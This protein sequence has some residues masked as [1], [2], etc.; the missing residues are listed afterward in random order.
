MNV[1]TDIVLPGA[2]AFIMFSMGLSLRIADFKR[3]L[4]QPKA[5]IVGLTAQ[6]VFL[7]LVAFAL[8]L[9]WRAVFGLNPSLAVGFV[10]IAACPGGVTSNLMTHMARG[11]TA[12]SISLTAVSSVLS[13]ITIPLIVNAAT[14]L[15]L[16]AEAPPLP[17]LGTVAGVFAI[18]T[19][20]VVLGMLVRGLASH[21]AVRIEPV[22][23]R[24]AIG[25]FVV[26]VLAAVAL[27]WRLLAENFLDVVPLVLLLNLSTM[28]IGWSAAR[29]ARLTRERTIAITLEAGLQ[30]G[31]LA[32]LIAATFLADE[33]M[34]V[35]GAIYSILM[36]FTAGL[37]VAR[38]VRRSA[39]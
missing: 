14:A 34:V 15:F 6:M 17:I 24:A 26:I 8:V 1:V 2:L 18:V 39:T 38:A 33:T 4:D 32:V 28:A 7:P 16:G 29:G 5:A 21:A 36:F 10:I 20:P 12:L 11:D 37:F 9:A 13:A 22:C 27:E 25:L 30:N 23:R 19:L 3:V 31:T 35:P